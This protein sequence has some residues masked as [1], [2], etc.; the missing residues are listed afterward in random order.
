MNEKHV[1]ISLENIF[2]VDFLI[3]LQC[4]K[5]CGSVSTLST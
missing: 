2:L 5:Q 3:R 4:I 1:H